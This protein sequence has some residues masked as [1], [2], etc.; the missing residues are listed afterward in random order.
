[1]KWDATFT[2]WSTLTL[3]HRQGGGYL[4]YVSEANLNSPLSHIPQL[5][6]VCSNCL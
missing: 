3:M 5:T 4:C 6:P 2:Y 1:M